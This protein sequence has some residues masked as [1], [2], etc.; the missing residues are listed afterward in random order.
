MD[1]V[2]LPLLPS[3]RLTMEYIVWLETA[4]DEFARVDDYIDL[5]CYQHYAEGTYK[6]TCGVCIEVVR[7][8][9]KDRQ[10]VKEERR[11]KIVEQAKAKLT[12]EEL[13]AL[14]LS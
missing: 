3:G 11:L 14:R 8:W 9:Y 5:S 10:R 4:L 6:N 12:P 7:S 1:N 13:K 2:P